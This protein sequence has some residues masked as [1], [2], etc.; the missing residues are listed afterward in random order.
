MFFYVTYGTL[1]YLQKFSHNHTN[2]KLHIMH[3]EDQAILFY[4]SD[5][6]SLFQSPHKYEVIDRAGELRACEYAAF[7]HIPVSPESRPLFENRF[8]NRS[9][10]IESEPGFIALRLLRPIK[11]DTYLIVTLWESEHE[12]TSW[13]NSSS[14]EQ[15][16]SDS[17]PKEKKHQSIFLRPPYVASYYAVE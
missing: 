13:K 2:E 14:F 12:F 15:A 1:D 17:S 3:G 9:G 10:N 16:H 5:N 8:K 11:S 6:K 7:N 4:E